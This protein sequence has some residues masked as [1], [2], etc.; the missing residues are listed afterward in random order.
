MSILSDK[1]H[2]SKCINLQ[3]IYILQELLPNKKGGSTY[4]G[5]YFPLGLGSG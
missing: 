2:Y 1:K 4:T 3:I 5:C